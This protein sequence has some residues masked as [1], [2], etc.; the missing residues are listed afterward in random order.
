MIRQAEEIFDEHHSGGRVIV[1][2]DTKV[3]YGRLM[4]RE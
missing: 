2:Y 3:Y 4:S 1:E